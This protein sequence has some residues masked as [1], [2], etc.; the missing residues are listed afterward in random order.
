MATRSASV[1]PG[2]APCPF[3]S[4]NNQMNHRLEQMRPEVLTGWEAPIPSDHELDGTPHA[5]QPSGLPWS[6]WG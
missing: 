5:Q 4:E 3:W 1:P 2:D 6:S